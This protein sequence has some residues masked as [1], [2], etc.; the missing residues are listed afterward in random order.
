MSVSRNAGSSQ[1]TCMLDEAAHSRL[2]DAAPSKDLHGIPCGILRASS[3]VHFQKGD[4][5]CELGCLFLVR[6]QGRHHRRHSRRQ[7]AVVYVESAHHVT[8][9]IRDVLEPRLQCFCARDHLGQ[10]GADDGLRA[11]RLAK[12]LSL[13]NPL[14][15]FLGDHALRAYGRADHDPAFVVEV[16]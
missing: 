12:R 7:V 4:L 16:A 1:M 14:E 2:R 10:F 9:L 8:H 15:T 6:L 13:R 3:G 11:E 5:A